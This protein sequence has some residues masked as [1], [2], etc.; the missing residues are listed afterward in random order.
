MKTAKFVA[1]TAIAAFML[2]ACGEKSS[3][4]LSD[5]QLRELQGNVESV[6]YF[7]QRMNPEGN[8]IGDPIQ[9]GIVELFDEEGKIITPDVQIERDAKGNI[10]SYVRMEMVAANDEEVDGEGN[11]DRK[12]ITE[13]YV[14][15]ENGEIAEKTIRNEMLTY[16]ELSV[17][18][19]KCFYD[20]D[21]KLVK[22]AT[23]VNTEVEGSDPYERDEETEF[24]TLQTD[25]HGNW[26]K[27]IVCT[28]Q[29]YLTWKYTERSL[30]IREITY[31]P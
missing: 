9:T 4:H 21:K 23:H 2:T 25:E 27:R 6:K 13:T 8:P 20:E 16:T 11:Y 5:L 30:Q 26:T 17:F 1:I 12:R 19:S 10:I 15:D 14:Y 28:T 29:D 31:R 24:T 7:S 3:S 18:A 22:L